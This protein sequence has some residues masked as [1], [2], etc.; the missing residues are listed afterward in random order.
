MP[1][2]FPWSDSIKKRAVRYLL[3]HYLGHFL[4]EKLTLDQLSVDLYNGKGIIKNVPL[5]VWSLNEV[6]EGTNAPVEMID[7][8]IGSI[9]VA[10]PWSALLNDNCTM[11]IKGL[12]VTLQPK[13]RPENSNSMPGSMMNSIWQG[14]M[15]TSMQLAQ[16]CLK[17]EAAAGDE[18]EVQPFEGLE[19][20]AQTIETVLTRIKVT[21]VDTIVRIEHVPKDSKTGTALEIHIKRIEYFDE[22]AADQGSPVD[23]DEPKLMQPAAVAT[24][25]F[26]MMGVTLHSDEFP[27]SARTSARCSPNMSP[28]SSDSN[29]SPPLTPKMPSMMEGRGAESDPHPQVPSNPIKLGVCSGMQEIKVKVKQSESI[30]GPKFDLECYL[31]SLN[32]FLSPRQV[33]LLMEMANEILTP[34]STS[35]SPEGRLNKP[36]R[37]E[38]YQK[39]ESELQRQLYEDRQPKQAAAAGGWEDHIGDY[40]L[41]M[42]RHAMEGSQKKGLDDD[43]DDVY[44][45]MAAG[46]NVQLPPLGQP[47]EV[48]LETSFGSNYSASSSDSARHRL[49]RNNSAHKF[50]YS[51]YAGGASSPFTATLPKGV[52][53][54]QKPSS[55]KRTPS[56]QEL[57][58]EEAKAERTHY[59]LK[60]SCLS[61][62]LLHNDP[63]ATPT[64]KS[65]RPESSNLLLDMAEK[66]FADVMGY[67]TAAF[68]WKD[69]AAMK[70]RIA[71]ACQYDHLQCVAAP[72][73][74]ECDQKSNSSAHHHFQRTVADV[75]VGLLDL[76][77]CL[78]DRDSRSDLT[79]DPT[80]PTYTELLSF[81]DLQQQ[82]TTK[83]MFAALPTTS[84]CLKVKFKNVDKGAKGVYTKPPIPEVTVEV[85]SCECEVDISI[86]DR[87][88]ALLNPQPLAQMSSSSGMFSSIQ[89]TASMTRQ[90][91]FSQALDE[92]PAACENPISL[93]ILSPATKFHVR[94]PIP[95][96]RPPN[97]DHLP[98]WKK[99][100]RK[101]VL[102]LDVTDFDFQTTLGMGDISQYELKFR[103]VHGLYQRDS[104]EEAVSFCRISHG[105]SEGDIDAPVSSGFDWPRIVVTVKPYNAG[106]VLEEEEVESEPSTP[107]HSLE[108]TLTGK[109]EPSVFSNKK[110]MFENEEMI[111]PGDQA[112]LSHFQETTIAT[113][114]ICL[115]FSF[116]NVNLVLPDK[117]FYENLYNRINNDLCLWAPAAPSPVNPS[118]QY[119]L[120]GQVGLD[121]ASQ[122]MQG[123]GKDRFI[124][125]KS[126]LQYDSDTDDDDEFDSGPFDSGPFYSTSEIK[127]RQQRKQKQEQ[128]RQRRAQSFVAVSVNIGHG[129]LALGTRI[130]DEEGKASEDRQGELLLEVKDG[131]IF[132][133]VNY[134]GNPNLGYL[135][136]QTNKAGVFHR[137]QVDDHTWEDIVGRATPDCP[138]QLDPLIY[139][140]DS[141][142]YTSL[143]G[144]VGTGGESLNMLSVGVRITLDTE[145]AETVKEFLVAVAV[146]GGTLRHKVFLQGQHWFTQM[147]DFLDV[148]DYPILGYTLP[149]ILTELHIH[150]LG[151]AVDYR[152]VHLPMRAMLTMEK[153]SISSNIVVDSA[154]S[155]LRFIVD[156]S[157]LYLSAN[158]RDQGPVDL[159]RNYVCVMDMGL[160]EL[161]LTLNEGSDSKQPRVDLKASNNMLHIRT[162]SDSLAALT[163]L[164]QY[165]AEDGDLRVEEMES[166]EEIRRKRQPSQ[167]RPRSDSPIP[168]V[169]DHVQDQM[170]EA[171]M[172]VWDVN[173]AQTTGPGSEPSSLTQSP[174]SIMF[175]FPDENGQ[176]HAPLPPSSVA[177]EDDSGSA[178]DSGDDWGDDRDEDFCIIDDPGLGIMPRHGEPEVRVLTEEA[179][180]VEDNHFSQ[181]LGKSDLLKAPDHFP[182]AVLRYTLREMSV[183]WHMYG[184]SDFGKPHDRTA[185][186]GSRSSSASPSPTHGNMQYVRSPQH[187]PAKAGAQ[188]D[189]YSRHGRLGW[190]ARG[191]PGRNTDV[192]VELQ[193][194]KVR[195]QHEVFPEDTEQASRQVLIITE[196]EIRDRLASSQINK[197]L[198]QYTSEARPKQ[199][200]ANMVMIKA[201]HIRPDPH[202]KAQECCLR[203]SLLPLRLN[204]DQ[205]AINF[206]RDFFL[207]LADESGTCPDV[208]DSSMSP[209][210]ASPPSPVMLV[211][212]PLF[213]DVAGEDPVRGAEGTDSSMTSSRGSGQSDSSPAGP[214][215][216]REFTFSPE[217]P[218]RLDYHG[219]RVDMEQGAFAG[220]LLGLSQLNNSELKLR[221]L[222]YRHG[223]LGYDKMVAYAVTEWGEDIRKNQLPGILGGVGPMHSLVQIVQGIVD[224]VW[225]PIE[226]YRKDGRIVRGLQRGASSFATSTAMATLEL[227][228]RVVQS[229]QTAAEF[230]YD[231]L[232]SGPSVR[233]LGQG[234]FIQHRM[235]Q[236]PADVREG[237]TKAYNVVRE[238]VTDTA[239]TIYR[240]AAEQHEQKGVTGAVGGVL[241]QIPPT[242][243]KPVILATEATSNVIGGVRNQFLPDARREASEKW[244]SEEQK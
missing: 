148:E 13:Y 128:Y 240:V 127:Q 229:I 77:E 231:M 22:C 163:A 64:S 234:T 7:G 25:V 217:V 214:I 84:P 87:L 60:L 139:R 226:Q 162:C 31:G 65:D 55:R 143:A 225:L 81:P 120:Q 43:D 37:P 208:P 38:D 23:K 106:S 35:M 183:V 20:F 4:Q 222:N 110:V 150:L 42:G 235:A 189:S 95:D 237:V 68:G 173:G 195:L 41:A 126:A 58:E 49:P 91:L 197:F 109:Q 28:Q 121:L 29:L 194:N 182:P 115:E 118:D 206:L 18:Q 101:E 6:L 85:S 46:L 227:T 216:F 141:G 52:T 144:L 190:Q 199:A 158:V 59:R 188:R 209:L 137:G 160:F 113:A 123:A 92:T 230:T 2:Y 146:R 103:E 153:L 83:S 32:F 71:K 155:V 176:P 15:T 119:S 16:E 57:L 34:A 30:S 131:T 239:H 94:F 219:K 67:S 36:I 164:L 151:C 125:C 89:P 104:S 165:M 88:N 62:T 79:S 180:K 238:G 69:L 142:V 48:D 212:S 26:H 161:K 44:Y 51:S 56:G 221:R 40:H 210:A 220:L 50:G 181:P 145:K 45:S 186:K 205:D 5:D 100:V 114:R 14:S 172:D 105:Q 236:Q 223:L 66:Y 136:V 167:S 196:L 213:T 17:Q 8:Y 86:V 233:K 132:V 73:M 111:M 133:V 175:L 174:P 90:A 191:G 75:S 70:D 187:S 53:T 140:S 1:W 54:N 80:E 211:G 63:V 241:R 122:F 61:I 108:E 96:L 171:M 10:V 224:L 243:V 130:K 99:H 152:P 200:H 207:E 98:W 147:I 204:I 27:E 169:L 129:R 135:F 203:V 154:I 232:S 124:M 168:Q 74:L 193:M 166:S 33:H 112:E 12:E 39:I 242:M 102:I 11:E 202:L 159:K 198:Y 218:I 178:A 192:H 149:H 82:E 215:F 107:N 72:V 47:P 78:Y 157:A 93:H 116:P 76:V 185:A 201:L 117:A 177:T 19:L 244:R 3:Q 228:N 97:L 179:I 170:A 21:F 134:Q 24:K 9:S 184:G 138:D 156:D